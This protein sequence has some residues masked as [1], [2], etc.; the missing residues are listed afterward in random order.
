MTFQI[1]GGMNFPLEVLFLCCL[2]KCLEKLCF[3]LSARVSWTWSLNR[4]LEILSCLRALIRGVQLNIH[5]SYLYTGK[6]QPFSF[7]IRALFSSPVYTGLQVI[8]PV[9]G[10]HQ[11]GEA[12]KLCRSQPPAP[13]ALSCLPLSVWLSAGVICKSCN[14]LQ[15]VLTHQRINER[16]LNNCC[17][18]GKSQTSFPLQG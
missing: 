7:T 16:F 14:V 18:L 8:C 9:V 1:S 13:G 12:D 4:S 11:T 6:S 3:I 5:L 15:W 10:S 2:Y 17:T